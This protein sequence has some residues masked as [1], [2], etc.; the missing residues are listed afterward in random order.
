MNK[1]ISI[2]AGLILSLSPP[3]IAA[4][5]AQG[6]NVLLITIDTLRFDRISFHTDAHVQ[7]PNI[8][9]LAA[10]SQ[11][12]LR[13]YAHNPV[14]LPSHTNIMTGTTPIYHGI[15]D[16]LGFRLEDRFITLAEHLRS[17][18]FK[19]AAFVASF[20]LDSRF[21]LNQGFDLYND[22]YGTQKL[23]QMYYAQRRASEV[24][25]PAMEWIEAQSSKWF[26]WIHLFDP[27]EP[28]DP[29][30]PFDQ[31]YAGDPYSGEVAYIDAQ[32]SVLFDHLDRTGAMANTLIILTADHGEGMGDHGEY[33]H[34]YFA[35]NSV[36]HVPLIMHIPGKLPGLVEENASH[37]DI[38]PTVSEV[39]DLKIP[40]Q[41][42]GE[43]LLPL[44]EGKA[45]ARGTIYFESL[46]PNLLAGW[47][48]LR[49]FVR[50]EFKYIN[51][52]IPEV[53]DLKKDAEENVNLANKSNLPQLEKE[54]I[55]LQKDLRGKAVRQKLD[56][57][58]QD[59]IDKMRSLGY[60]SVGSTPKQKEYTE[61]DDL[62]IL[63]PIQIKMRSASLSFRGGNPDL[64][65]RDLREILSVRPDY[66]PAYHH[67]ANLYY[68]IGDKDRAIES[69]RQGLNVNKKNLYLMSR[70]G[71]MLVEAQKY[72]EA[73][74]L[75]N[76]CV[77]KEKNNPDYFLYLGVAHQKSGRYEFALEYY[78]KTLLVD[79]S[80]AVALNNIGSIHLLNSQRTKDMNHYRLA[81]ANFNKAL[82][83][84]PYLQA[85][86]NGKD[87]ADKFLNQI[88]K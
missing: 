52:P 76:E 79:K 10:R 78:M 46:T 57:V 21:G 47:A 50:G 48:P 62:K 51:L 86:I 17:N 14:T 77:K 30:A 8:D 39:L 24:I 87:A 64:A 28:Y 37:M 63:L 32:L 3:L 13:A 34:S 40:K 19:T 85:A 27:H 5:Q 81:M 26:V 42:Q 9:K 66:L 44:M 61:R 29:P 43:S 67:M 6:L 54:L 59:T 38:F 70:L 12:F 35:Y 4:K 84:N 69:L 33:S 82:A 15:S 20:P 55:K 25:R 22:N 49:G 56:K 2:L 60:I 7:T 36:L 23:Y 75:L 72:E 68:S 41:I 88:G 65:L 1:L 58:E 45:R 74:S 18:S 31:E 16:N 83:I 80:H 71:L 73:I 53:Y 11:V